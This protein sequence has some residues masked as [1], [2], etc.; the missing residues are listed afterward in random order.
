VLTALR[1]ALNAATRYRVVRV[2]TLAAIGGVTR[3]S[4]RLLS[5]LDGV[6]AVYAR[7][8]YARGDFRPFI[9]DIDFAIAV[10][11]PRGEGY[12]RCRRLHR[13]L[14]L[15]RSLNP[16]VRDPWQTILTAP[17]WPLVGRY[18]R[19]L[20]TEDWRLLAGTPP[21]AEPAPVDRRTERAAWWNRQYFWTATAVRQALLGR[22][23]VREL[24]ASLKKARI[25]ARRLE[26]P[27]TGP[28][29]PHEALVELDRSA[30]GLTR[31]LGLPAAWRPRSERLASSQATDRERRG[32]RAIEAAIDLDLDG[33]TVIATEWVLCVVTGRALTAEEYRVR[34]G[35]LAEVRRST[36]VR[37]SLYSRVSFALAPLTRRLKVLREGEMMRGPAAASEPLLLREQLLYQS[38]YLGTHLWVA[39]GRAKPGRGLERHVADAL[40]A[41]GYFASGT[42]SPDARGVGETLEQVASL[43]P[44]LGERLRPMPGLE[45]PTPAVL[46]EI[47]TL[48]VERLTEHLSGLGEPADRLPV[49]AAS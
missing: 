48:A 5:E 17:Q 3:V 20:G 38:L 7:G 43:D 40:E 45:R 34:L 36:G 44:E 10:G 41:C 2:P 31:E 15:V 49:A 23:S 19:L 29:T 26:T 18:G 1:R 28:A 4:A 8:S 42:L 13:R 11:A 27:I 33:A 6:A 14:H 47:G 21:W 37:A 12:R 32:L 9:S 25:F 35:A 46:F 16:F 30:A 39:A 22:T 24:E